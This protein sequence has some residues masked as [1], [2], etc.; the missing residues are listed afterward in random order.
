MTP[1]LHRLL[2][3]VIDYAGLFPPAA[4]P[5]E[6]AVEEFRRLQAGE[7]RWIVN[8]FVCPLTRLGDFL[9]SVREDEPKAAWPVT[10]LGSSI[11]SFRDDLRAIEAFEGQAGALVEVEAYEVKS[12]GG[13]LT[14]SNL[15]HLVDAGFDDVFVELPWSDGM[16]DQLMALAETDAVGAK[17]RTGGVEAAAFPPA[18][19]LAAFI[20]ENINLDLPL[21][22]TAGLHHPLPNRDPSG[23]QAHGFLNV[24]VGATLTYVHDLNRTELEKILRCEDLEAFWFSPGG[25]GWRDFEASL[26]EID[27]FRGLFSSF[28]SCSVS[29]PL[30]DLQ[31]LGLGRYVAR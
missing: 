3:G 30:D 7:D 8:R 16:L 26:E 15:R 27:D 13:D 14:P 29:E 4:L 18:D 21:K 6:D 5:M 31:A 20:Q 9:S 19:R 1:S 28:G 11:A 12:S 24:L 25:L 2:A 23:A 10:V 17:A 22:L